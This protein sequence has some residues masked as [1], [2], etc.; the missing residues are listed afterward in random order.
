MSGVKKITMKSLSK[1]LEKVK[2]EVK[3]IHSLRKEVS[4]LK[5]TIANLKGSNT[6]SVGNKTSNS[7]I[8]IK[9]KQCDETFQS[10]KDL[11]MH[12][13]EIHEKK[14]NCKTCDKVFSENCQLEVHIKTMHQENGYK[15]DQCDKTFV[16]KWRLMKHHQNHSTENLK[17]CHYFNN[18]KEC[19]FE[20]LG[21]MFAHEPSDMC[22][23]NKSCQNKL[24]SYQHSIKEPC[25]KSDYS[26]TSE[27][28]LKTHKEE[29]FQMTEEEKDFDS[30]VENCFPEV[31]NDFIEGKR[32]LNC[33]YCK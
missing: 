33:Y 16:L 10:K 23:Y 27:D 24:C 31:F 7:S 17:C 6:V 21:C 25:A 14:V 26:A 9:C 2:E 3:E 13:V 5:E 18:N 29:S 15:C 22:R 32:Y 28:N 11:K 19:P 30:Y 1:E 4:T 12:L 20:A 8:R